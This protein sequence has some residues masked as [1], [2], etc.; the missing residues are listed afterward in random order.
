MPDKK[1]TRTQSTTLKQL[2]KA[3][4]ILVAMVINITGNDRKEVMSE[5]EISRDTMSVY[6]SGKGP[7]LDLTMNLITAF[8]KHIEEREKILLG[9]AS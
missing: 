2:D 8:Q 6:L 1:S 9:Q 5:L 4:K 7:N 3:N